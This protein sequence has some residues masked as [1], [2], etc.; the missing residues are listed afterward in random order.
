MEDGGTVDDVQGFPLQ[1]RFCA[2]REPMLSV[3]GFRGRARAGG[4]A[5]EGALEEGMDAKETGQAS[6]HPAALSSRRAAG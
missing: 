6:G 3:R 1:G 5:G 4:V 2:A